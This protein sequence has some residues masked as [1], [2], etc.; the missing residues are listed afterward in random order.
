MWERKSGE[1]Q[2][3]TY[4]RININSLILFDLVKFF[5]R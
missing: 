4:K 2:N 5:F 1:Y 3:S